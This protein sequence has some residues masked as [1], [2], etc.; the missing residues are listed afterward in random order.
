[1]YEHQFDYEHS[2]N[3]D[4]INGKFMLK[5]NDFEYIEVP[6]DFGVQLGDLIYEVI[7]DSSKKEKQR[8][9]KKI[10]SQMGDSCDCEKTINDLNKLIAD[11]LSDG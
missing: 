9:M 4:F 3:V 5:L 6:K 8:I 2:L 11:V 10:I 7:E 1:M